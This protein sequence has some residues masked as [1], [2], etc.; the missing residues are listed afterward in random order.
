MPDSCP[1]E[2]LRSSYWR[3]DNL[4]QRLS[5]QSLLDGHHWF[6]RE[7]LIYLAGAENYEPELSG[8][9][10]I[11]P[12]LKHYLLTGEQRKPVYSLDFPAELITTA[13]DWEDLVLPSEILE[14]V[15]EIHTWIEHGETLLEDWG[16]KKKLKPGYRA[17][18]Y[19]PPGTGKT[20]TATLLGKSTG[21]DV[22]RIDLSKVVSKYIGETEKN[23]A[24]I[25]DLAQNRNW[26]L[27]FDEADA[28]F[29]KRTK[30]SSSHD[31]YANQEV[32][33]LLQRIEEFPGVAILASNMRGNLDEAFSRRF[34]S[35]IHFPIPKPQERLQIWQKSFSKMSKLEK[36]IDLN[37]ISEKYEI[38][39]GGVM[40]VIRYS[41]L[42]AL[43]R[44][45][46]EILLSDLE[47]GIKK[48]F[49]KEG[50]TV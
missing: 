19:G 23:L 42:L 33:Y 31:K 21:R 1:Q 32:S 26:I 9:L 7:R 2:R 38:S 16:M 28:L 39:G 20:L 34:Q 14:N 13:M 37:E 27:F 22:Y 10:T 46:N 41:S 35:F 25:F 4:E 50:R 36:D 29:G 17:L 11:S 6:T 40:N 47:T 43:S 15:E 3:A 45:S 12:D 24:K 30:V 5:C 44:K 48:E 18:F 8:L 49:Q